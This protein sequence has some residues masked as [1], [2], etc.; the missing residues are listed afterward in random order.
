MLCLCVLMILFSVFFCFYLV[1][2]FDRLLV[3]V[4]C[5]IFFFKQKTAYEMRISDWSSDV[6]SSDLF[7]K[8][9]KI[10]WDRK[11]GKG[12]PFYYYSY[13]AAASEVVVDTLTGEYRVERVDILHDCGNSLNPALDLG[14]I[15]GGFVQGMGWLTTEELWWD[16]EGRLRT[17]APSTYKIPACGDRP[18]VF[19]V[20]LLEDSPNREETIY[21]SKAVGEP[22]LDRT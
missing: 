21:R 11:A 13:G 6:C 14:Q 17:H 15:E 5:F 4:L 10:H 3:F 18:R 9:P 20:K 8:T 7:Y 22:P 12:R 19:N 1:S 16:A 2:L